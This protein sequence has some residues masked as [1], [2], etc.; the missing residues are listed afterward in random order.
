M[1]IAGFQRA[2]ALGMIGFVR[3]RLRVLTFGTDQLQIAPGTIV[4]PSHRSDYDV[5][6][7][8]SVVYPQWSTAAR[9]GMQWPTF[10]ADDDLFMRGFLAG[11]PPQLPLPLRR[12]LWPIRVGG[13]LERHLQCVPVRMPA[14]MRLVELLRSAPE[15]PLDGRLPAELE[16]SLRARAAQ[17]RRPAPRIARDVLSGAYADLLWAE[18][19]RDAIP[20]PAEA[21]RTHLDA[22][23]RDFRQLVE[24][25][26]AGASVVIFPE[27]VLSVDGAIGPVQPGLAS[28][29]RRARTRRLQPIAIA[30]DPLTRGRARAYVSVAPIVEPSPG[31]L[32][33]T[34][35]GALRANTPLTPG[36]LAATALL[37]ELEPMS[38]A[39]EWIERARATGRPVEPLLL[40][41]E[42]D[43]SLRD[44]FEHARRR[45][46]EDPAVR[47]LARELESAHE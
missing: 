44:S 16:T 39:H 31:T 5:P 46:A 23:V 20:E 12:M 43:A 34:V 37:N 29:A 2:V 3:A 28:L 1:A 25:L 41:P 40:G 21:W 32:E 14:R 45:G 24:L 15:Q 47:R 17:L 22:A 6:L 36:Q 33:Q 13:P 4:A 26:R 11:Y 38:T 18:V 35:T 27:G 10:A 7:L 42:R 19:T 9:R 8:M 30:Y